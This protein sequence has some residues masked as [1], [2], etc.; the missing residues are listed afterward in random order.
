MHTGM[1]E[2]VSFPELPSGVMAL[3]KLVL[4]TG[5]PRTRKP[6]R[7]SGPKSFYLFFTICLFLGLVLSALE[8]ILRKD[9]FPAAQGS[10]RPVPDIQKTGPAEVVQSMLADRTRSL[11]DGDTK[12]LEKNYDLSSDTGEWAFEREKKRVRYFQ[13]WARLRGV[14]I[15]EATSTFEVDTVSRDAED[16]YW[17]EITEHT[18]Y[19]YRYENP[20][21]GAAGPAESPT[22]RF[23]SRTVHAIELIRMGEG[24]VIR[25]DWYIDPLGEEA[26]EPPRLPEEAAEKT[27]PGISASEVAE[28]PIKD[29]GF[30]P[31]PGELVSSEKAA[32][33]LFNRE[34]AREYA[35]KHSG[36]RVLPEGGRYNA[37]YRVYTYLGGD[38]ANFASQVLSA[39]G[40]PQGG[41][42]HYTGEGSTAWVQGESLVWH[43][44]SSGKG[45]RLFRGDYQEAVKP[46]DGCPDGIVSLLEPGDIIAYETKGQICHVAVVVGKDPRGYV[47]IASHTADRLHFPWDLGWDK[48]TVF[49]FIKIVY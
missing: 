28:N 40:V 38:C 14:R 27:L 22:H 36:V 10:Y 15:L 42:W 24:W 3:L 34:R 48:E 20:D 46:R 19:S 35:I 41:G 4:V 33:G 32:G 5:I 26:Y 12:R 25:M 31:F 21:A 29:P 11:V 16:L 7:T 1:E 49:W 6:Q 30:S 39:G 43:L 8:V 17:V 2:K 44:L 13:E 37:R 45:Q 9:R 47:T 18:V 23:G